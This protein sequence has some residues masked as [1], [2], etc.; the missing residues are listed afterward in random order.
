M[1][2][3]REGFVEVANAKIP[4]TSKAHVSMSHNEHACREKCLRN[5]SCLAYTSEAEGG[6][7]ANCITWYENLMDVRRHMKRFLSDGRDLNVRVDAVELAQRMKSRRLKQKKVAVVVTS[8]VSTSVLFIILVCWPVMKKRTRGKQLIGISYYAILCLCTY[9]VRIST[10]SGALKVMTGHET[11]D[12]TEKHFLLSHNHLVKL[13]EGYT[14]IKTIVET[15]KLRGIDNTPLS[16][17]SDSGQVL[18]PRSGVSIPLF[19]SRQIWFICFFSCP[20][21]PQTLQTPLNSFKSLPNLIV[22]TSKDSLTN[23]PPW[24]LVVA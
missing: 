19:C 21:E 14:L 18:I 17:G 7:W 2:G 8:V 1:C 6:A 20:F 5:C 4:N 11:C 12:L 13:L 10:K 16:S 3:N 24:A 23:R 22:R 9:L 15:Q